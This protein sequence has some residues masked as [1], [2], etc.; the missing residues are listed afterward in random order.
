MDGITIKV[1][2]VVGMSASQCDSV[3]W[4]VEPLQLRHYIFISIIG[5]L[6]A[7]SKRV[8]ME[9][10]QWKV[11][12]QLGKITSRVGMGKGNCC[13]TRE[14]ERVELNA[15]HRQKERKDVFQ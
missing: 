13:E 10:E 6:N 3:V 8:N 1:L 4:S 7:V 11:Y 15:Q 2:G 12:L 14:E 5:F 9:K